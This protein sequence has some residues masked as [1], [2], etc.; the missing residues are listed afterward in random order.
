VDYLTRINLFVVSATIFLSAFLLFQVQPM[1]GRFIL[2]WF[3]GA[4][5]VWTTCLLFFQVMLLLGYAYAHW[6]TDGKPPARQ[7]IIHLLLLAATVFLLPILPD[8][9]WKPVGDE[10]PIRHILLLLTVFV[11]GPFFIL[12]TTG[13]LLQA[14][15]RPFPSGHSP[16]RLFAWTNTGALLGLLT[17]PFFVEPVITR[18]TQ[19]ILWSGTYALVAG[20]CGW[21]A[22]FLARTAGKPAGSPAS[23]RR[24]PPASN[25]GIFRMAGW[26]AMA[27]S[28]SILLMSTTSRICQDLAV[29]FLWVLP[30]GIY[31]ITFIIAFAGETGYRRAW[32]LPLLAAAWILALW[33]LNRID[34]VAMPLQIAIYSLVLFAGC[35]VCHGELALATP[36]PAHLTLFYLAL[37]G[38][39]ALGG[40]FVTLAAPALFS[41][42]YEYHIG[43]AAAGG[44]AL[45]AFFSGPRL[46][47]F[48]KRSALVQISLLV[49]YTGFIVLLGRNITDGVSGPLVTSRSFFGVVQIQEVPDAP[50]GCSP[51]LHNGNIRNGFQHAEETLIR[52]PV[53]SYRPE[54][55]VGMAIRN[56]PRRRAG[57]P[58]QI[59]V[60]G[61][62]TGTIAAYGKKGDQIRFY[63]I[64]P[65]LVRVSS[66]YFDHW[67]STPADVR[68]VTGDARIQLE[69][70]MARGESGRFDLL[71]IDAFNGGTIPPHLL[72]RECVEI[73]RRHMKPDAILVLHLPKRILDLKPVA[74]GIAECLG[75]EP[76][77]IETRD[78]NDPATPA[79][80]CVLITRNRRVLDA[81]EIASACSD[82]P[83]DNDVPVF[84]TDDYCSVMDVMQ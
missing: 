79:A 6:A 66:R 69:R 37:A 21:C 61:L 54:V 20:G 22:W 27:A 29:S 83:R 9:A 16:Y 43:L 57:K 11:G 8:R 40:L 49:A 3:G 4:P 24:S 75:W 13:P 46:P 10:P 1:I 64:N 34:P 50:N 2:P 33:L 5:A 18:H 77:L 28:A 52:Q 23:I 44:V 58:I 80:T 48:P 63:E 82:W 17:Y 12:S 62:G 67:Q 31:L 51:K 71:V 26:V 76:V 38:G 53:S 55:G 68:I 7:A 65:D 42:Y 45:L 30:L 72:T 47:A 81:A 15:F 14:W 73:Y 41:G 32:G 36:D 35:M 19:A 74:L 39:G 60:I 84:W 59:G 25:P 78:R 70:E 56:H